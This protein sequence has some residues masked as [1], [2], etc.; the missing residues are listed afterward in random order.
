MVRYDQLG[1]AAK[2]AG[3]KVFFDEP[4]C[5]HT[6]FKIG[7]PAPVY[8]VA[9]TP[10]A[11]A[12]LIAQCYQEEIPFFLLGKGSTL[13]VGDHGMDCAV[14]RLSEEAIG[15]RRE[16]DD[17]ICGAGLPLSALASFAQK[18][19]LTGMEFSWGIPGTVGGAVYMN[20]GA[21]GGEMK[22][23]VS[24]CNHITAEGKLGKLEGAFLQ[25]SYRH[26][27]Y[28]GKNDAIT[29]VRVHLT[30]GNGEEIGARM[31][32]IMERRKSKPPLEFPSAGSVF[33]R[34]EGHFAGALIEQCGLK[35]CMIG[36][37]QVSEK[38]AG[39]IINRGGATSDDVLRLVEKIQ[40]TVFRRTGI[41]LECEI[42][43]VGY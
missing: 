5:R 40:E 21:Y 8:I 37:A 7:G 42:K 25:F 3:C 41:S 34:P 36:G 12:S 31:R 22:Q 43:S 35:G 26:S 16:D 2:N 32:N 39:F 18:Q 13:L 29:E 1:I 10:E 23:V 24:R 9:D 17:I 19:G 11:L 33:K 15:I 20:A 27:A 4:L 28:S 30:P 14:L 38:H 6:T